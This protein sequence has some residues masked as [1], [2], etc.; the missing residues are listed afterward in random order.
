M[1]ADTRWYPSK[2][3]VWIAVLLALG[4]VVST[5]GGVV[6][7]MPL[8]GPAFF[9]LLYGG[10]VFPMR[11]GITDRELVIR[12]GLLRKRIA[13]AEIREVVPTRNPRSSHALSLDRLNIR[14]G[15]GRFRWIMISPRDQDGFLRELA[16]AA[17]LRRDGDRL[18]RTPPAHS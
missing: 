11:Y 2:I 9:A 7:G 1:A 10:L 8:V 12:F 16:T 17:H 14:F 18:V 6:V 15:D 5:M 3:D 13:L 4:P